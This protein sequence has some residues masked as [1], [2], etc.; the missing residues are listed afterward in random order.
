[1]YQSSSL[2]YFFQFFSPS[3]IKKTPSW[4]FKICWFSMISTCCVPVQVEVIPD[5][6]T[7]TVSEVGLESTKFKN[8][9]KRTYL[10]WFDDATQLVIVA[11]QCRKHVKCLLH[12]DILLTMQLRTTSNAVKMSILHLCDLLTFDVCRTHWRMVKHQKR[13]LLPRHLNLLIFT[14]SH[15]FKHMDI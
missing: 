10:V 8:N 1:M 7:E 5:E 4:T 3:K 6:P 14:T 2:L 9:W 13:S 15:M 12:M 11:Y